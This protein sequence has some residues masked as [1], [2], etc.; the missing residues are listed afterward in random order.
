MAKQ[1]A[2]NLAVAVKDLNRSVDFFTRLGFSF[3]PQFTDEKAVA[4]MVADNISVMLLKE[5]FFATFTPKVLC[6]TKTQSEVLT[7]IGCDSRQQV[8]ELIEKGLSAGGREPRAS[9]DFGFMYQ[10]SLEGLDGH[11][12]ELFRMDPAHL[13]NGRQS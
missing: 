6:D 4:M 10:R 5:E 9:M 3:N 13:K 7:A 1:I 8:D 12:W 2:V 11:L